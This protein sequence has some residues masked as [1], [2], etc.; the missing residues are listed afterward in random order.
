MGVLTCTMSNLVFFS[1]SNQVRDSDASWRDTR[2]S[3]R[4]DSRW[5]LAELLERDE[6]EKIFNE[7]VSNL[8]RK[9]KSKFRELLDETKSVS[10]CEVK[11]HILDIILSF[12]VEL[13]NCFE[14][15]PREM[16][17]LRGQ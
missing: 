3:L 10:G 16:Y 15:V 13:L 9:K 11:S 1:L 7:H 17:I 12:S 6:K 14:G 4:K 5:K 2:R 8:S